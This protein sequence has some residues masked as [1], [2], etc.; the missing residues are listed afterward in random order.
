MPQQYFSILTEAGEAALARATANGE[1]VRFVE[2]AV[3]DGLGDL[4]IPHRQQDALVNEVYRAALN[5]LTQDPINPSQFIAEM[6]LG[7]DL[8][9]WWVREMALIDER[10]IVCAVANCPPS[11]K[12]RPIEG[13]ARTLRVQMVFLVTSVESVAL[14]IDPN[15]VLVTRE[16]LDQA[17]D[18]LASSAVRKD[19]LANI[20][21][22]AKADALIAVRQPFSGAVPRTQH[23]KNAESVS[24]VDFGAVGDG[25]T[26]DTERFLLF[27]T[28]TTGAYVDL[29]NRVY[30]VDEPPT[31]NHYFNGRFVRAE[32]GYVF[33]SH[34]GDQ[35]RVG[36]HNVLIGGGAGALMPVY[37]E[38]KGEQRAYA[39]VAIG[40]D[41]LGSSLQ[42]ISCIAIGHGALRHL[43][44]GRY[45]VAVGLESQFCCDSDD[46]ASSRGTRNTSIGDNSLRFNRVGRSNNAFG[47][48]AGQSITDV[49][50]SCAFGAAA[51]AGYAPLGLD[52]L[53]IENQTPI[54]AGSQT[55]VGVNAGIYSN[56]V[57]N[58]CVG[59]DAGRNVKQGT[60]VAVGYQAGA[61]I[62]TNVSHDGRQLVYG[63][64]HGSYSWSGGVVVVAVPGHG[65]APGWRV[66][67][68]LGAHEASYMHIATVPDADTLTFVTAYR[69]RGDGVEVSDAT[70][71][72]WITDTPVTPVTGVIA[73]GR[74]ALA[75][76]DNCTNSIAIGEVSQFRSRGEFNVSM[77][78][79]TLYLNETGSRNTAMGYYALRANVS[80]NDNVALGVHAAEA[81]V[82]G[83]RITAVGVRALKYASDGSLATAFTNVAG[84]GSD[85]RVSGNNQ[86]QL[87][88]SAT[89]VYA[90]GSV[91]NRSD[92]RDKA[93]V[94][95]T[96]LGLAFIEAL[97]PV[98][99]RWDARDDYIETFEVQTGEDAD[100]LP[101]IVSRVRH[102]ARDGSR[103]RA[104]Y[105]HGLIAQDVKVAADSLGVDFGGYQD[106]AVG[107]GNDVFSIGYVELIPVLIKAVQELSA[108]IRELKQHG[109]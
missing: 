16:Y 2:L 101:I 3:G 44:Y 91:Q 103:K 5:N 10:G 63:S 9:G 32:D 65:L 87:G 28:G 41:A 1:Q 105:H 53:T 18:T 85:T 102:L 109:K 77:G 98:D 20:E 94:R 100:G 69:P 39:V 70:I 78:N 74:K 56:A 45:N 96:L 13:A 15:A 82:T 106:H 108:E 83:A 4:P 26:N 97:R 90:F 76:G 48:N 8:G 34:Q 81:N 66:K 88:D 27:E 50:Y 14:H 58:T 23:D 55:H 67:I 35:V 99:F 62:E 12:P 24:A 49:D 52:D 46:N 93:D 21:D 33:D 11:Y 64:L 7:A 61:L 38:Y 36:N 25:V 68:T 47:R 57:G 54:T 71:S 79:L 75:Q 40:H 89:T 80:G 22:P 6:V 59:T 29:L 60:L 19:D 17:I 51:Q 95:D 72:E 107:G 84:L 92:G 86:V 104:R 31:G 37:V 30:C 43:Q 73:I 42:G